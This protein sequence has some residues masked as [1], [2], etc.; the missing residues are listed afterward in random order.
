MKKVVID[1]GVVVSA[2]LKKEGTSRKSLMRALNNCL[3]LLAT[4]TFNELN[5]VLNRP[6]FASFF[7]TEDKLAIIALMLERC[8][9]VEVTSNVLACRDKNDNMLLNLALDGRADILLTRDPD[10]LMLNPF[11]G[12]PILNPAEF[13][14]WLEER[15]R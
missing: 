7:S 9:W 12:I 8:E 3:P 2:L 14:Q 15:D 11:Q 10:L 6:K 13:I 5:E 4:D 1:T